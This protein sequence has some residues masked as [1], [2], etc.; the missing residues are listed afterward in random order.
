MII[1]AVEGDKKSEVVDNLLPQLS[2][3]TLHINTFMLIFSWQGKISTAERSFNPSYSWLW[4]QLTHICCRC[5]PYCY[6]TLRSTLGFC[7]VGFVLEIFGTKLKEKALFE[8][9]HHHIHFHNRHD[10]QQ[11]HL[12]L[13][14]HLH[15]ETR[16]QQTPSCQRVA[17]IGFF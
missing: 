1:I 8:V 6:R 12:Q 14:L 2:R 5:M 13:H 4:P 11:N 15:L 16:R 7:L 9:H 3:W 10:E 17:A